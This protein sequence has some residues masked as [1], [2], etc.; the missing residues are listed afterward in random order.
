MRNKLLPTVENDGYFK[1]KIS[2]WGSFLFK[3]GVFG[4]R[5]SVVAVGV[6]AFLLLNTVVKA[7]DDSLR[8]DEM[9]A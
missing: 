9:L 1:T 5:W 4:G 8:W 6:V 3:C 2:Q 7:S